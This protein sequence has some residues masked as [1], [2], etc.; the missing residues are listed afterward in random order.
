MALEKK[1][2]FFIIGG[3][4]ASLSSAVYLIK[5]GLADGKKIKIFDEAKKIGGSLDAQDL[6]ES[7]GY[8]MRGI[9][10]FEEEAFSCTFDLL[11][12]IPSLNKKGKTLRE[13]FVEFNKKNK[14]YSK[15]R[16]I[17]NKEAI[18]SRPLKLNFSDRMK[19]ITLLFKKEID[20]EDLAIRDFFSSSF[21]DSNFWYEFCT[22][23]AFQPWHSAI[24]FRRY[25]I[26]FIQSF[27]SI[28][29]LE[30]IEISPYN[31][32]E[33]MVLPIVDWLKKQGVEFVTNTK[34]TNLKFISDNDKKRVSNIY[35]EQEGRSGRMIVG[36]DDYV[37]VTL[38][39]IVAN[40]S[41][42]S[43]KKPALLN[44]KSKSGAWML[45]ENISKNEQ[46]FGT[47]A[48]FNTH[49]DKS[50]WTSFTITLR[51]PLFFNLMEKFVHK[52][53]TSFGGV[54][55]LDSNW[56]I[57]LV[58]SYKPYFLNQT[59]EIDLCWG[60][61]LFSEREGNFVK[62]KMSECTG[63]EILTELIYHLGFEDRLNEI[64]KKSI[65]IPC[66]TPY[67]TSHFLPRKI[68][69]RP[70]VVP[71]NSSNFA[72]LGQYCEIPCDVVFTVEYSIRSAQIAV[73]ELLKIDKKITPIYKG[74]HHL[75]VI[76]NA[77]R[78]ICR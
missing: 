48:V 16:L 58:L 45:W 19:L 77:L 74:L 28:D 53:V 40:S 56:L 3:G 47:P 71:A 24:E 78:T 4:I 39:S 63:A 42:G 46:T 43:M 55:L 59:K 33:F 23:F 17:R 51:D 5:D 67:V 68:S 73:Y 13:E 35:Y 34:I 26:R 61:G 30:T 20:L 72:F 37:F 49:L 25:F 21:F 70:L 14:S 69:D 12:S 62:K 7:D 57:S 10:M 75:K 15:S 54:N 29:T 1:S 52:K 9:R 32:Y 41:L 76:F 6:S 36:R 22:V 66:T 18:D 38:G 8:V 2:K 65:C 31:Q 44:D 11:S 27:P 64:L 60:F 50:R